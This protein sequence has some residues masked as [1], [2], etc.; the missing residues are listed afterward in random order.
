MMSTSSMVGMC[1][2]VAVIVGNGESNVAAMMARIR[3]ARELS[4][5]CNIASFSLRL[6]IEGKLVNCMSGK[7][8]FDGSD[9]VSKA[10]IN[11]SMMLSCLVGR[12]M[13]KRMK[14]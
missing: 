5:I 11:S 8:E 7:N 10:G 6:W 12:R 1:G 13:L 3:G 4:L 2:C 14:V 9:A